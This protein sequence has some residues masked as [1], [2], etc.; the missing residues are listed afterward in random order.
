MRRRTGVNSFFTERK[1]DT[2]RVNFFVRHER[3]SWPQRGGVE[4]IA[5]MDP[6]FVISGNTGGTLTFGAG[7]RGSMTPGRVEKR[8]E[9]QDKDRAAF[10]PAHGQDRGLPLMVLIV[11]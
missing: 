11:P 5:N 3:N 1:L 2:F 4:N 10:R 8:L 6:A 9:L 7:G